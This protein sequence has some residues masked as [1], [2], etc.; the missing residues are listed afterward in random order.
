MNVAEEILFFL[1]GYYAGCMVTLLTV[2]A[3]F[4]VWDEEDMGTGGGND[5][6]YKKGGVSD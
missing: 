3:G 2:G 4:H 5:E 6:E 1:T